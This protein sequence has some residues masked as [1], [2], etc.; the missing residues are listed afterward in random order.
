MKP[1]AYSLDKFRNFEVRS[2]FGTNYH[3][4]CWRLLL[5]HFIAVTYI[6]CTT[7]DGSVHGDVCVWYDH[8][9]RFLYGDRRDVQAVVHGHRQIFAALMK[10]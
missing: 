9:S 6:R 1:T 4:H 2:S 10:Q 7:T 8:V 3:P 5:I